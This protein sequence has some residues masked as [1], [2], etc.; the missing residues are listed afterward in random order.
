MGVL[1]GVLLAIAAAFALVAVAIGQVLV[2]LLV[3]VVIL[4]HSAPAGPSYEELA[5][6][7]PFASA[8]PGAEQLSA[9]G[10]NPGGTVEGAF[11]GYATR[12]FV[13]DAP[14][15]A[16]VAW[17]EAIYASDGWEPVHYG[18]IGMINGGSTTHAWRKGNLVA[19][20]G[21]LDRAWP[22]W[23]GWANY[24]PGTLCEVTLTYQPQPSPGPSSS[25]PR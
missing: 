19:G 11:N 7:L 12:L 10:S 5:A 22:P 1:R 16:V 17:H 13:A 2:L 25:P 24:P 18:Y 3:V 14:E 9:N 21:V 6:T 8:M 23:G 20:L 15:E 4:F